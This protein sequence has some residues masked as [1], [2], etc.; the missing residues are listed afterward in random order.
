MKGCMLFVAVVLLGGAAFLAGAMA[1]Q[2]AENQ[3]ATPQLD[4]RKQAEM[5]A[6]MK[7]MTPGEHHK[8]LAKGAGEWDCVCRVWEAPGAEPSLM[9]ATASSRMIL[10][11]RYLMDEF[12]GVFDDMPYQGLG[13]TTSK[14]S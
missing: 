4:E 6:W 5:E 1:A 14:K 2:E 8:E 9:T 3:P 10:G 7:Y 13:L 12:K 11:G